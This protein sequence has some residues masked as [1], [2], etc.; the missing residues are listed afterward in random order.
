MV[1]SV[2]STAA[3]ADHSGSVGLWRREERTEI[4]RSLPQG[5]GPEAR[6]PR[7]HAVVRPGAGPRPPPHG[8]SY[9]SN[10]S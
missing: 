10:V 4:L 6:P 9:V 3:A 5:A 7:A 2:P 1:Y 8:M